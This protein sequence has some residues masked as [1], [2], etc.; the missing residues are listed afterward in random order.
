[1]T[2]Q[3]LTIDAAASRLSMTPLALRKRCTKLARKVGKDI[4]ADIGDGI[5]AVRFGRI[6]RVRFPEQ[7]TAA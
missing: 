4:K 1:M 5:V 6:W 2:A 7:Q 3:Y